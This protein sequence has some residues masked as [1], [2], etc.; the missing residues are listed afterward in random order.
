MGSGHRDLIFPL[1]DLTDGKILV[2]PISFKD[3]EENQY[4]MGNHY[5]LEMSPDPRARELF[6]FENLLGLTTGHEPVN[7]LEEDRVSEAWI[8]NLTN[9]WDQFKIN[10]I[11][12]FDASKELAPDSYFGVY[13]MQRMG[14]FNV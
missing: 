7:V 14:D 1:Q 4:K 11:N 8:K 12:K 10:L 2:A 3:G 5:K 13:M 6:M 9:N